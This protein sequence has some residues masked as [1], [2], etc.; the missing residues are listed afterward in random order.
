MV[1]DL[2]PTAFNQEGTL[3]G[4]SAAPSATSPVLK[5]ILYFT[6]RYVKLSLTQCIQIKFSYSCIYPACHLAPFSQIINNILTLH[7]HHLVIVIVITQ[8]GRLAK[9]LALFW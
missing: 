5:R 6:R 2:T 4:E 7:C 3:W 1:P 8:L 9:R